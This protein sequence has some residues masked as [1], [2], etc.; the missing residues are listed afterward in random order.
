MSM[1][2]PSFWKSMVIWARRCCLTGAETLNRRG[3]PC[4][5]ILTALY[6][7]ADF[8]QALTEETTTIPENLAY[9]IDYEKMGGIWKSM[10]STPSPPPMVRCMSFRI[11]RA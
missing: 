9:Y 11:G 1:P 4:Q 10:M 7:P 2:S 6:Q 5:R 8:A 3:K